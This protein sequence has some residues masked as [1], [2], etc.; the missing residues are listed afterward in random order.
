MDRATL[1]EVSELADVSVATAS[2]VLSGKAEN[3]FTPET[4][5]RVRQ[6]ADKLGYRT[7]RLA[8]SLRSQ[9][10][11]LL[12]LISV[13]VLTTPYAGDMIRGAQTAA[14]GRDYDLLIVEIDG[15]PEAFAEGFELLA[16]HRA[17]GVLVASFFHQELPVPE[18][19]PRNLVLA[20]AVALDHSVDAFIPNEFDSITQVLNLIGEAGHVHV[21]YVGD[22][23]DFPAVRGREAALK[24]AA[25]R[26]GWVKIEENIVRSE[27]TNSSDGYHSAIKLLTANRDLTAIVAYNDRLAMGVYRAAS[28]LGLEIPE[29]LSVVGFDDQLLISEALRPG[30]TTVAL[31]HL[32]MGRLAVEKLISLVESEDENTPAEVAIMGDLVERGSVAP[33]RK[34]SN[35][36]S[37]ELGKS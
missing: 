25:D 8:R 3:R 37:S 35:K 13:E 10:T 36:F 26:F 28:E 19:R 2:L 27:D 29:D 32:E 21:G 1:R 33:P 6:A 11:R 31:P 20:D 7:N 5:E 9:Q 16:D 23:N 17:D 4:A 18:V 30:L 24:A 22:C 34:G 12:G 15:T 14:R